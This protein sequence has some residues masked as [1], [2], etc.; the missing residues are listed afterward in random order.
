[1]ILKSGL[2][3]FSSFQN[4]TQTGILTHCGPIKNVG[5]FGVL[6][7][8]LAF[9]LF[10]DTRLVWGTLNRQMI[11]SFAVNQPE[12]VQFLGRFE[13]FSPIQVLS[14]F[15]DFSIISTCDSRHLYFDW[16]TGFLQLDAAKLHILFNPVLYA[17]GLLFWLLSSEGVSAYFLQKHLFLTFSL[18]CMQ[19]WNADVLVFHRFLAFCKQHYWR[20][21]TVNWNGLVWL[22]CSIPRNNRIS[23][24]L[25]QDLAPSQLITCVNI[26]FAFRSTVSWTL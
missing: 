16:K 25:C 1:M 4:V 26:S 13:I 7:G 6:S 14:Q 11:G 2:C 20:E 21:A 18:C 10:A 9:P 23:T 3:R 17:I 5:Y 15:S 22:T 8:P 12:C 19:I 24:R